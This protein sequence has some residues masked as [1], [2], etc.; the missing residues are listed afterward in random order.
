MAQP[1][2]MVEKT[3]YIERIKALHLKK[4][5]VVLSD[6]AALECFE[7]LIALVTV[8]Y[9]PIPLDAYAN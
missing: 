4:T 6:R 8:T 5:G 1:Y 3:K 7:K 2:P 9:Q